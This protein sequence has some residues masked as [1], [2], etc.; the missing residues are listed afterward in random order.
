MLLQNFGYA[1]L[2]RFLVFSFDSRFSPTASQLHVDVHKAG[3]RKQLASQLRVWPVSMWDFPKI[4]GTYF[5][6]LSIRILLF[7]VLC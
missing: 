4:R 7:S 5:G 3:G 6:V 1:F 2:S